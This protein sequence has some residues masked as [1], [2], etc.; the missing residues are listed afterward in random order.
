[1]VIPAVAGYGVSDN[2]SKTALSYQW[3]L[4]WADARHN[5]GASG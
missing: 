4:G 5:A 3:I 1:M 2:A